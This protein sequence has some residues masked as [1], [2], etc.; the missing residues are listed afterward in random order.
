MPSR[1]TDDAASSTDGDTSCQVALDRPRGRELPAVQDAAQQVLD[2][3]CRGRVRPASG[4]RAHRGS[5]RAPAA[6]RRTARRSASTASDGAIST[7]CA[8]D[9]SSRTD[10]VTTCVSPSW[11]AYARRVRSLLDRRVEV[12]RGPRA[13]SSGR[14]RPS[15]DVA[16]PRSVIASTVLRSPSVRLAWS[17]RGARRF[18]SCLHRRTSGR[19]P[20]SEGMPSPFGLVLI[21]VVRGGGLNAPVSGQ[22]R[23]GSQAPAGARTPRSVRGRPR[24]RACGPTTERASTCARSSTSVRPPRARSPSSSMIRQ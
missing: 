21:S 8:S 22:R 3:L 17:S 16:S 12:S 10:A 18:G 13:T 1:I 20:P 6:A 5:P 11:I 24:V 23:G 7:R 4:S 19:L 14:P 15:A 2:R 9:S